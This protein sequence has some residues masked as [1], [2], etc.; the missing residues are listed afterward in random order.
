MEAACSVLHLKIRVLWN[1][2]PLQFAVWLFKVEKSGEGGMVGAQEEPLS[3]QVWLE[4][5]KAQDDRLPYY[6]CDTV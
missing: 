6:A 4:M 5:V 3:I 1:L 2:Q